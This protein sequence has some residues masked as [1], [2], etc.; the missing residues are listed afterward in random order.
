MDNCQWIGYP[1]DPV[2]TFIFYG[3]SSYYLKNSK[4][5]NNP[6]FTDPLSSLAQ[7][8]IEPPPKI[9]K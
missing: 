9:D 2:N 8:F 5:N 4:S 7:S 3:K 1:K 6:A